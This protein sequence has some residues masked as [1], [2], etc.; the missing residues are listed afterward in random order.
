MGVG[1]LLLFLAVEGR[2]RK[3]VEKDALL[4]LVASCLMLEF[5]VMVGSGRDTVDGFLLGV[6]VRNTGIGVSKLTATLLP[7]LFLLLV[8]ATAAEV[9]V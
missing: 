8:V 6:V 9:R 4:F 7:V 5:S 2:R 1:V 3:E